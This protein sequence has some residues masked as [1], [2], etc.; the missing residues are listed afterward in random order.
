MH[1]QTS[2]R[3]PEGSRKRR[4][5]ERKHELGL[6]LANTKLLSNKTVRR[7]LVR[8]DNVKW[9]ALRLNTSN[10][11]WG[12]E[13]VTRKTHLCDVVC[14]ELVRTQT[15]VKNAIVQVDVAPSTDGI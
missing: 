11:P 5:K 8:G 13:A 15:M 9:R 2:S 14:N 6:H 3:P 1:K 12:S 4:E 10:F 7:V